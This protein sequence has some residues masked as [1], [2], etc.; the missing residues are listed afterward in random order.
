MKT[1]LAE[2]G[3]MITR[4]ELY[5]TVQD[6]MGLNIHA[7]IKAIILEPG[8][9]IAEGNEFMVY[10]SGQILR[11]PIGSVVFDDYS[12]FVPDTGS[13]SAEIDLS[14][15]NWSSVISDSFNV[16]IVPVDDETHYVPRVRNK[17]LTPTVLRQ[18]IKIVVTATG[19]SPGPNSI[20]IGMGEYQADGSIQMTQNAINKVMKLVPT[21]R[22]KSWGS[23]A[24]IIPAVSGITASFGSTY[25]DKAGS[26]KDNPVN[27]ESLP[28]NSRF[29]DYADLSWP[30]P[31]SQELDAMGGLAYYAVVATPVV[32]GVEDSA[33]ARKRHVIYTM[34]DALNRAAIRVQARIRLDWGV[35]YNI[36]VYRVTNTLN[37]T[38]SPASDVI[39]SSH[40]VAAPMEPQ[41]QIDYAFNASDLIM[42]NHDLEYSSNRYQKA[43]ACEYDTT[44]PGDNINNDRFLFYVGPIQP[45]IY[46]IGNEGRTNLKIRVD[47]FDEN[48]SLIRRGIEDIAIEPVLSDW[49]DLMLINFPESDT[50]WPQPT[51]NSYSVTSFDADITAYTPNSATAPVRIDLA[52]ADKAAALALMAP[53]LQV[54]VDIPSGSYP[55]VEGLQ[56]I[57]ECGSDL[58]GDPDI[59]A[60][61]DVD[62]AGTLHAAGTIS[63]PDSY[64]IRTF[65]RERDFVIS[66]MCVRGRLLE[67]SP[68][69]LIE[70]GAIPKVTISAPGPTG[71]ISNSITL[72]SDGHGEAIFNDTSDVIS[73]GDTV[74]ITLE[75]DGD[76]ESGKSYNLSGLK[77][78]IYIRDVE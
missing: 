39:S 19:S 54:D 42:I 25:N 32:G 68:G 72:D 9:R 40:V 51:G 11:I 2:R 44:D 50:G 77:L 14:D 62:Y 24:K 58:Y 75:Y 36:R 7:Y 74:T 15:I 12:I 57:R 4:N 28:C 78:F 76:S 21:Y 64:D 23:S 55:T 31:S 35:D 49:E 71:P 17:D 60:V 10:V 30:S 43:Y 61:L 70:S 34:D 22:A 63:F 37:Y 53:G 41:L 3:L 33:K 69:T 46:K 66:R 8:L 16:W 67:S 29:F 65:T 5:D 38:I 45:I 52:T 56:T 1:I 20:L 13:Q 6:A 59:N 48:H 27:V 73:A 47:V 18:S 26:F